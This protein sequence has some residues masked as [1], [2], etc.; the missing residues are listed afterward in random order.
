MASPHSLKTVSGVSPLLACS[1]IMCSC[2]AYISNSVLTTTAHILCLQICPDW[3]YFNYSNTPCS[4][5]HTH[6]A[7]LTAGSQSPWP[8]LCEEESPPPPSTLHLR[9]REGRAQVPLLMS[10]SFP[11]HGQ[12]HRSQAREATQPSRAEISH[13]KARKHNPPTG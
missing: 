11:A 8:S 12:G 10:T 13:L 2:P 3:S 4:P 6:I 7:G 1:P 5:A 9:L